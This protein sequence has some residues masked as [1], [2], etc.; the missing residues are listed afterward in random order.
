MLELGMAVE[1]AQASSAVATAVKK[2]DGVQAAIDDVRESLSPRAEPHS[3]TL[4]TRIRAS[5]S[6]EEK[7]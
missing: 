1:R 3:T 7:I 2:L 5:S 6:L 4:D